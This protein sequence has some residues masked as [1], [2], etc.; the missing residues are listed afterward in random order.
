MMLPSKSSRSDERGAVS[1]EGSSAQEG[2]CLDVESV[3]EEIHADYPFQSKTVFDQGADVPTQ[4]RR[5]ARNQHD[6]RGLQAR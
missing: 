6:P 2:D 1:V 4:G 3:R 5:V